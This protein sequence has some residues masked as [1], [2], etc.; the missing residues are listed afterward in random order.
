MIMT[1]PPMKIVTVCEMGLNRSLHAAYIMKFRRKVDGGGFN[2]V[3]P[4]G[5]RTSTPE[6]RK[7]LFDWAD[8]IIVVDGK[9]AEQISQEYADKVKNW[10]VGPDR[11]F[12]PMDKELLDILHQHMEKEFQNEPNN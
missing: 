8:W 3:V 7:M 12:R 5:M 4:I 10:D 9:Y 6:L 11:W 1:K 2:D